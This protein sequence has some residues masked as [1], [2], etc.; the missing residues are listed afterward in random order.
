M[1]DVTFPSNG[2]T[3]PGYLV[4]PPDGHGLPI[5]VLQEWWGVD[6]HIRAVCDRLAS[7][8]FLAL[9]PDLYRGETTT[10]PDEAEQKMMALQHGSGR[11]R[12]ARRRRLPRR[13]RGGGGRGA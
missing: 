9:A 11:A 3:A 12:D 1:S 7:N 5:V 4:T 10:Q 2:S 8:G 6:D 13:S